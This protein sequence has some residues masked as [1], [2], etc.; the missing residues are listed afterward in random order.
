MKIR[1]NSRKMISLG[2]IILLFGSTVAFAFLN[3]FRNPTGMAVQVPQEK[4]LN[5]EL[6]EEQRRYLLSRYFTLVEFYY[7]MNCLDCGD[8]RMELEGMA[9]NS[10]GQI[11]LQELVSDGNMTLVITSR[12]GQKRL[13][14]PSLEEMSSMICELLLSKPLWCVTSEI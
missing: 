6:S 7:P 12:K 1:M 3:A 2:F 9:Q 8:E 4:I 5:Y 11:F 13:E 10:E 14:D